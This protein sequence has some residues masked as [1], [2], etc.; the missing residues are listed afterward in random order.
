MMR[1]TFAPLL[2]LSA[3]SGGGTETPDLGKAPLD[4]AAMAAP[5]ASVPGDMQKGCAF[6]PAADGG[7]CV[8]VVRGKLLDEAGKPVPKRV[9]S[10]CAEICFF[11]E[12]LDDGTFAVPIG[13]PVLVDRFALLVHGRPDGASYYLGLPPLKGAVATYLAPLVLPS[14]P[15]SG[16]ALPETATKEATFTSSGVTLTLA[17][18]TTLQ[19]DVEDF[20]LMALGKQLRVLAVADPKKLAFIDP[21]SPPE[22]LYGF[23]PFDVVFSKK[24]RLS[25][26]NS[27]K[28]P[29]KAPVDLFSQRSLITAAPPAGPFEK[30]ATAHVSADGKTIDTDAS[31]GV[32]TLTW[33]ALRKGQ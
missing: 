31:E 1:R 27:T 4:A 19:F 18:G 30:V 6:A 15:K 20:E 9:M 13:G 2:L 17:A 23:A 8:D 14:L 5:D 22:G 29:A 16:P 24:A 3:C 21:A 11:G 12:T 7:T 32:T 26:P 28:L 33:I 25:F 10:V